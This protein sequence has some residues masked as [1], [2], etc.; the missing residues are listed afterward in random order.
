MNILWPFTFFSFFSIN[1]VAQSFEVD[2][3]Q[4]LYRPRLK[5]ETKHVFDSGIQDTTGLF[6]QTDANVAFT[7]PLK[8]KISAD[9]KLDLS[10]LKVKDILQNSIR[11][12]ASQTMGLLK[13]GGRQS[14]FGFDSI[15]E[16]QFMNVTAGFLGVRLTRKYRVLFWSAAVNLSEET[17]VISSTIP[18]ASAIIGQ[19]HVRGL[20]K[21][22]FYGL[23]LAYSDGLFLPAPFFGGSEPIGEKFIFNYTLPVQMNLQYK[24]SQQMRL[25]IGVSA[26]GYRTGIQFHGKRLNMNYTSGN[27]YGNMRLKFSKTFLLKAEAGY[28]IY[29]ALRYDQFAQYKNVYRLSPGPYGQIGI[30]VLFGKSIW[31]KVSEGFLQNIN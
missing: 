20:R 17:R 10:S 3:I 5:L 4:Q 21:N 12:K 18:R 9:L 22:F 24:A 14:Y 16:K 8:T 28:V 13:V 26:E 7:F 11:L 15:P 23:M 19:M 25:A 1:A 31:E 29:Q 30:Q 2:Q 27:L 6:N